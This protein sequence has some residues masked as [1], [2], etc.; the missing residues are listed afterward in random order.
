MQSVL[1]DV[2]GHAELWSPGQGDWL[3]ALIEWAQFCFPWAQFV[4]F[5]IRF[6]VSVLLLGELPFPEYCHIPSTPHGSGGCIL[7]L[8]C[9][10]CGEF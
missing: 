2:I 9:C 8:Q 6:K 7:S 4:P 1:A 3:A 10:S 5:M